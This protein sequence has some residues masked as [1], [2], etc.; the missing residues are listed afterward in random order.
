MDS[1]FSPDD[2]PQSVIRLKLGSWRAAA[3]F[4]ETLAA[5]TLLHNRILTLRRYKDGIR[6]G[7]LLHPALYLPAEEQLAVKNFPD[8]DKPF[9]FY[10]YPVVARTF[11]ELLN[12]A[13]AA[14]PGD[15]PLPRLIV[16]L[17][18]ELETLGRRHY[19]E[20][21]IRRLLKLDVLREAL[22]GAQ[23]EIEDKEK[24]AP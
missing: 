1:L 10:V 12:A 5:L 21:E 18:N 14:A 19:H 8:D 11:A 22:A 6:K 7:Q 24:N 16:L 13:A 4:A 15:V 2:H 3:H 9:S 17:K 23:A 20:D